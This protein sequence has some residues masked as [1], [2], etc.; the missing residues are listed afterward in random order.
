[1]KICYLSDANS[2]HTKKFCDFFKNKGYDVS[3]ISLNDG[4]IDG[5]PVYNLNYDMNEVKKIVLLEN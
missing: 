3:V 1:M 5:I 4:Y 2:I